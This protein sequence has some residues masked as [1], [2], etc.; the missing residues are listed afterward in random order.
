[1]TV[2][3][4]LDYDSLAG[5]ATYHHYDDAT[6]TTGIER[7]QDVGSFIEHNKRLQNNPN[8]KQNGMKKEFLHV[9]H[10]P[11]IIIEKWL[12]EEGINVFKK[13]DRERVRKKLNDPDWKYLRTTPGK[14]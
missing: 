8:Y 14:V 3:R 9:A 7:V 1:M 4:L 13:Q 5:I 6:D 2:K 11:N 12:K 10:I